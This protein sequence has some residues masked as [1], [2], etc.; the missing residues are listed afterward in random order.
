MIS[1]SSTEL[2]RKSKA[3]SINVSIS[4]DRLAE[5]DAYAA[6]KGWS[7]SATLARLIDRAMP[8][9]DAGQPWNSN[10]LA[11]PSGA[12]EHIKGASVGTQSGIRMCASQECE[13]RFV[14]GVWTS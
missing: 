4:P 9:L 11:T 12:H 5:L 13:A 1:H 10:A 6:E 2:P 8:R 3:T 7:R 14:N